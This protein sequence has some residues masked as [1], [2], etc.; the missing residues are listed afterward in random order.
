[1]RARVVAMVIIA[2]S[3]VVGGLSCRNSADGVPPATGV[4]P[5]VSVTVAATPRATVPTPTATQGPEQV[6]L[7]AYQ[8]YWNAYG[9]ALLDLNVTVVEGVA[10]EARLQQI[11]EEIDTLRM[12]GLAARTSMTHHPVVIEVAETTA[13]IFDQMINNSF[14]VDAQTK[15]PSQ[16]SGSGEQ[17]QDTYY[18]RRIDGVW[19][20]VNSTRVIQP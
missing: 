12:R 11:R 5:S 7:T 4:A 1:M 2:A 3:T 15:Q 18:L 9:Q 17:I 6:V 20:V 8:R 10:A 19:K 13:I 16:A 14:Y